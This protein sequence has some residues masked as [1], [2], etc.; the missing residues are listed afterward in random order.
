MQLPRFQRAIAI[1][2]S[3]GKSAASDPKESVRL[4]AHSGARDRARRFARSWPTDPVR[5][6]EGAEHLVNPLRDYFDAN[7]VGPGIWKWNHY[8][9][10]YQRHLAKFVGDP[11]HIVEVGVYSG[12]SLPMWRTYFG[13]DAF[14]YG[15][16]IDPACRAHA[17]ER[18]AVFIG[19]QADRSFWA[20]FRREVPTVDVLIDDGG[21]QPEQQMT[22]LEEMLP[23][24]RLGGV[25]I[26]E[27]IHRPNNEF[28]FFAMG[29]VSELNRVTDRPGPVM[30][31]EPSPFQR[32]I[33]SIHFYPYMTVIEKHLVGPTTLEA[34]KHGTVWQPLWSG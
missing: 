9:D 3:A 18:V 11:V 33:H 4:L 30:A 1:A 27:D 28:I 16:D 34:P 26:C 22:T 6:A 21:H 2:A 23:H 32:A 20:R 8:F 29:L 19:D 12:G 5:Q 17:G 25:Y 31:S 13:P 10:P 15:V 7:Q 14:V 24:L